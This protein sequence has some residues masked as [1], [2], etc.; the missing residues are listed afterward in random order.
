MGNGRRIADGGS[1][2][3]AEPALQL[4]WDFPRTK[5]TGTATERFAFS[6]VAP[7]VEGAEGASAEAL[8]V[9]GFAIGLHRYSGQASI[10][11]DVTRAGQTSG[12][13]LELAN[14]RCRQLVARAAEGLNGAR[15][16]P[17]RAG[18]EI[19]WC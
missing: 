5:A 9:A 1:E 17:L 7:A 12:L 19:V 6:L 3:F 15:R 4:P 18:A 14:A 2:P 10:S 13:E 16:P 11:L 8:I